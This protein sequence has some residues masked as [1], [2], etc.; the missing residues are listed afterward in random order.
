MDFNGEHWKDFRSQ[1]RLYLLNNQD[2]LKTDESKITCVLSFMKYKEAA[3]WAQYKVDKAYEDPVT[4]KALSTPN[5]GTY[6]AFMDEAA[7]QF[8]DKEEK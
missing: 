4:G 1:I 7:E 8:G 3:R 5:F 2:K 6:D